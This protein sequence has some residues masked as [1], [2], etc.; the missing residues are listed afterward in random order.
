[1]KRIGGNTKALMQV[2]NDGQKNLIGERQSDWFDV[3]EFYGWL[4][5]SSGDSKYTTYNAKVQESTH[6][7]ICDFQSFKALSSQWKWN[8]FNFLTGI[9]NSELDADIDVTSE[10]ARML[11]NN[12][13][14]D[15]MIIDDPMNLHQHLEIYLKFVGG[16]NG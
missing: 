9:I 8:P 13:V 3:V 15:I 6:I 2:K 14:Y 5:F 11:I 12:Q 10:N 7:F 4:D 16:Q 1:M